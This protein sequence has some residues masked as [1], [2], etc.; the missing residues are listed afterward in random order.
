MPA[1]A[2]T[3]AITIAAKA[4][5]VLEGEAAVFTLTRTGVT[6]AALT[7]TVA[8]S[9]SRNMVHGGNEGDKE[10]TFGA[11]S[12]TVDYSVPTQQDHV[13]ETDSVVT[14]T[15]KA[16]TGYTLG[17][18]AAATV[19]VEDH[20]VAVT[21]ELEPDG[22]ETPIKN[23]SVDEGDNLVLHFVATTGSDHPPTGYMRVGIL[24]REVTDGADAG[25][26]FHG[27]FATVVTFDVADFARE[28]VGSGVMRY[29]ATHEETLGTNEDSLSE[30]NE[31]LN[32]ELLL[33]FGLITPTRIHGSNNV[34]AI[35]TII[36]DDPAG[37]PT[38]SGNE[39][40]GQTLTASTNTITDPDGLTMVSYT[41][42]WIRVNGTDADITGAM[43]STY[44]LQAAD[45]GKTIK[46]QVTFDDDDGNTYSLTS[47]ATGTVVERP[48]PPPGPC[49]GDTA[50]EG[51]VWTACLTVGTAGGSDVGYVLGGAGGSLDPATFTVDGV[52]Y[53]VIDITTNN[54]GLYLHF[55]GNVKAPPRAGRLHAG[56]DTFYLAGAFGNI[57]YFW[58]TGAPSWSVGQKVTVA[59][60]ETVPRVAVAAAPSTVDPGGSA[61][62]TATARDPDGGS[63]V[64]YAWSQLPGPEPPFG[65]FP[66]GHF[67]QTDGAEVAWTAPK[68]VE[69][70]NPEV[71]IQVVV[72][73]DDGETAT[74]TV[75]IAVSNPKHSMRYSGQQHSGEWMYY[76][77][78]GS[79][80]G[81]PEITVET[82]AGVPIVVCGH[83]GATNGGLY[84]GDGVNHEW[85]SVDASLSGGGGGGDGGDDG[86]GGGGDGGGDGGGNGGGGGDTGGGGGD[87]GDDGGGGD[88]GGGGDTG[89]GSPAP[90]LLTLSA[91]P[92]PAE[93][94]EPVTVTATLD[95]PAPANGMTVTLTT[96]GTATR[97][98]DYALSST[99]IT[100][101]AGETAGTV[102]LTVTDDAEDDAGETIVIDAAS[103]APALTAEPLTLTI[104][105]ND[106]TP[107]PTL[108]L[109]GHLLLALGLTAA[110][111]RWTHQRQRAPP[112]A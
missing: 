12:A 98:T 28:D 75:T 50:P 6:T 77:L 109:L 100:F 22:S 13:S 46:V 68:P 14:A 54:P 48:P 104:E 15:L 60:V 35:V 92:V 45:L 103:T 57:A 24:T 1:Q 93:G 40:V 102:T 61:R 66:E 71:E 17:A 25:S 33:N 63:I 38:I 69:V 3:P 110:G 27:G 20:T 83:D 97:D 8:I 90:T 107:V 67:D 108:P 43:S 53:T 36:D 18:T 101:A 106:V 41:Y 111:S 70:E 59:L 2:Q 79:T 44:V 51:A 88:G 94:G 16:D 82:L 62:L 19:T 80:R 74:G 26:D 9:E 105:D 99:T 81:Q 52:S 5:T 42:Q 4:A 96:G 64:S 76:T 47:A 112:A 34:A 23:L 7:V 29:R 86:G 85:A 84:C 55:T 21:V 72:T 87:G 30:G 65:R 89:G 56:P 95:N 10:A 49:A 11:G 73:D 31:T 32:V 78:D 39:Q 91:A 58:Q 37:A